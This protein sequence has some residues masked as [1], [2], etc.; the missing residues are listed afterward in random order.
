MITIMYILVGSK[1]PVKITATQKVFARFFPDESITI[2]DFESSSNVSNQP[3]GLNT[4]IQ[5][6]VKSSF[7]CIR[8]LY[9]TIGKFR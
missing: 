3:I 4:V 5:G 6:A 9:G 1:N 2:M 7:K 8:N